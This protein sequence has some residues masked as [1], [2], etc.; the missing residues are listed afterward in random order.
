MSVGCP[1]GFIVA[2]NGGDW[3]LLCCGQPAVEGLH[4][5]DGDPSVADFELMRAE[6]PR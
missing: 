4:D 2:S 6:R 3:Q 1:S 5:G